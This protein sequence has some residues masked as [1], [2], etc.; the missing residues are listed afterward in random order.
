[1]QQYVNEK[2]LKL[3]SYYY[4]ISLAILAGCYLYFSVTQGTLFINNYDKYGINYVT[5]ILAILG[6]IYTI[7]ISKYIRQA[8][9]WLAYLLGYMFFAFAFTSGAVVSQNN[10]SIYSLLFIINNIFVTI[11]ATLYGPLIS[12]FV[13][14]AV[15]LLFIF[16][17]MGA[18]PPTQ[19]GIGGDTISMLVR[20]IA[21]ATLLVL[22]KNKYQNI[23]SKEQTNYIERFFANNAVVKLLTDSIGDGVIIIDRDN[24]IKSVNPKAQ[25]LLG[26]EQKDILDL[27]YKSVLKFKTLNREEIPPSDN[28][29]ELSLKDQPTNNF[30]LILVLRSGQELFVDLTVSTIINPQSNEQ[31]GGIMVLRDISKK[32]QEESARSEFIST[33]SHEMRTP[34]AAI[35]GYL[36]LALNDRVSTIDKR[37]RGYLEK[38]HASTES[39]GKL[40]QDLLL[41]AKAEDGRLVN[42]PHVIELGHFLEQLTESL[43][44]SA[45]KK[46][47]LVDFTIGTGGQ[48]QTD[49]MNGKVIKPLYYSHVDPERIKEVITNLF[50]NAVKY[51]EVGKI[52]IGLTGN[53]E[54][55][56]IFI[57]DT[58]AGIPASDI[59]HLFQKF[60]RVDNSATRTIGG[61]GLGLFI[62]RKIIELYRGRIWVESELGKGSTFYINLPRLNNQ[63]ANELLKIE[64]EQNINISPL[65]KATNMVQ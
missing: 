17:L 12:I 20:I 37:A 54:I 42:K 36:G 43:Q 55:V 18:M 49:T 65:D 41:S 11:I 26:Q 47:L 40:F 7:F 1:M 2:W 9:I 59:R 45:Q 38:A 16:S 4:V 61:T 48:E 39:L 8:N 21:I 50:D 15:A 33:A 19:L 63:K 62:C 46:G 44:F 60:Y 57:K 6:I 56:Q 13:I 28:P 29:I 58:G 52:S 14:L 53:N 51:T 31:Y 22:L 32:K 10:P 23:E 35:E 3:F 5:G 25:K 27:D 24:N 30:E 64:A 34:V